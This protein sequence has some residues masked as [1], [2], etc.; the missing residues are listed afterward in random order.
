MVTEQPTRRVLRELKNAGFVPVPRSG[1]HTVYAS[2]AI[3]VTVPDGHRTI[4]PGVYR[5][6]L[7]KIEE[8]QR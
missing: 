6:I 4:S 5:Q 7:K 3:S 8:A 1:S 2:G